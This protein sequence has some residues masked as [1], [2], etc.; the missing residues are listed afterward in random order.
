MLKSE[1]LM[2]ATP[3]PN[4]LTIKRDGI[5]LHITWTLTLL[6]PFSYFKLSWVLNSLD[7]PLS[8]PHRTTKESKWMTCEKLTTLVRNSSINLLIFFIILVREERPVC[9]TFLKKD[10]FSY[11]MEICLFKKKNLKKKVFSHSW[12]MPYVISFFDFIK[13]KLSWKLDN[14]KNKNSD[15]IINFNYH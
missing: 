14:F 6:W 13:S 8:W 7:I 3:L 15:I 11:H 1:A 5:L 12:S 4:D 10:R 9:Y 2:Y